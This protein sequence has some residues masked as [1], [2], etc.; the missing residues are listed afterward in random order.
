LYYLFTDDMTL[1][2]ELGVLDNLLVIEITEE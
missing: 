2:Y 1:K